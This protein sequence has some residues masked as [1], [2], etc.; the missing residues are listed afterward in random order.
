VQIVATV[1]LAAVLTPVAVAAGFAAAA[2]TAAGIGAAALSA[3]IVTGLSG[4]NLGQILRAGLIAGA[5]AFAFDVVGSA[6]NA[7]AGQGFDLTAEH[8]QPDFN[9]PGA[10]AFNVA[11]HA[12]V[13]CASSAASGGSCESGALSG[14]IT[15]AAGPLINGQ[16]FG[17]ALVENAVLGGVAS[18][19][20][21]G[22]FA[23]GAVTG[24]FG[25][26][27]NAMGGRIVGG[28][29]GGL[30]EGALGLET[31]PGDAVILAHGIYA[32]GQLGSALEDYL[33]GNAPAALPAPDLQDHHIFPRQFEGFFAK[34]GIDIDDYTVTL[35][36]TSHLQG[37]HGNGLG[38][39]PGAWNSQWASFIQQNPGATATQVYQQAGQMMDRYGISDLPIHPYRQRP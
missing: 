3:S 37:I 35:G 27:F 32:W 13:G 31:G 24:A 19:A 8:I 6:T 1:V 23:N 33:F 14:G 17:V 2:T 9:T 18:V 28:I 7:A 38:D 16:R 20:G 25:Y 26:L 39:M 30:I 12:L 21:G 29:L 34:V 10:Y 11:G 4:G 15:A 5:T 36:Q 22:K